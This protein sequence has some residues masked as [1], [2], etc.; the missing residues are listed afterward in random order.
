MTVTHPPTSHDSVAHGSAARPEGSV[1]RALLAGGV[2]AA[3][4]FAIVSLTQA[5]TREGF[6]LTRHPLSMLA[7]GD[8][9]RLQIANFLV[10]GTLTIAGALGLR[11]AM[12]GT[13]GGTWAPRLI[14]VNGVG[15]IAAG[16]FVM[17]PGDGFPAGT[18]LGQTGTLS[19]H[20]LMHMVAGSI[21]FTALIA[22][23]FV[24]GRHFSRA[25]RPGFATASR[26]SGLIFALGDGW[27]MSGGR[28]GSL[29][30]A[31]GAITAMTWVAVTAADKRAALR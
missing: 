1:T 17:D 11:R 22:A 12:R 31:V 9:G 6:D 21:A 4:L 26:L 30:L 7:T 5:F 18:P 15:M 25:G 8:L 10:S 16:V 23:C 13:P 29:T 28:A 20:A 3:P 24:L 27:A 19:W 2:A 14:L